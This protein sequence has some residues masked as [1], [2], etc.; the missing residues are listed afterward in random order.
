MYNAIV[1]F[2]G[3]PPAGVE[4][5]VYIFSMIVTLFLLNS[6]VSLFFTIFKGGK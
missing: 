1:N 4:P 2:L 3:V 5:I 6:V